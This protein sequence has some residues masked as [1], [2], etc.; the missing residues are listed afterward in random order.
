VRLAQEH[1]ACAVLGLE[2]FDDH[3][4]FHVG[5][6]LGR[7]SRAFMQTN[8]SGWPV[9]QGKISVR[10]NRTL[11]LISSQFA[12]PETFRV[13]SLCQTHLKVKGPVF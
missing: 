2:P 6:P 9:F 12:V 7:F 4:F 5:C 8:M 3:F 1:A 11:R 10:L 13:P